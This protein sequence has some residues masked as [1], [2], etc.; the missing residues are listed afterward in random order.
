MRGRRFILGARHKVEMRRERRGV[1]RY[2]ALLP[3]KFHDG[4][5]AGYG[6]VMDIS[7]SGARIEEVTH[8]P[9]PGK[10]LKILVCF[11]QT[12]EPVELPA[13]VV[14]YTRNEGFAIR[15]PDDVGVLRSL[16]MI[17]ARVEELSEK[18]SRD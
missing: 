16:R 11:D 13:E 5:L 18:Q 2:L 15:F 4:A 10:K 14:R 3:V 9:L 17:L 6:T 12:R 7:L 8:R 1:E